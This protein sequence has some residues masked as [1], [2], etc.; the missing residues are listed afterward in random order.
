MKKLFLTAFVLLGLVLV[1]Q[2]QIVL[3]AYH[4]ITARHS[5]KVLEVA[6]GSL[7][8]GGNVQQG[9]WV[10]ADYQ[11]WRITIVDG[12]YLLTVSHSGKALDVDGGKTTNGANVQQWDQANV[13]Q[14]RWSIQQIG[15]N[16]VPEQYYTISSKHSMMAKCLDVDGGKMEAGANVQQ[17][18]RTNIFQQRWKIEALPHTIGEKLDGGIV[19]DVSADGL[20]GLIAE[21]IDQGEGNWEEAGQIAKTGRHSEAGKAFTDW[22]LPSKG[23]LYKLYLQRKIV[24]GFASGLTN[25]YYWSSTE[26]GSISAWGMDFYNGMQSS[27]YKIGGYGKSHFAVRVRAVR[28]F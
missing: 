15:D 14:Q 18:D 26:N 28:A 24:G 4:K 19:F 23:E 9:D 8:N 11:K 10:N 16:T 25:G 12:Y 3:G 7:S 2:A 1:S 6:N 27:N 13:P 21:T 5:G 20:H 22:Y 17:W